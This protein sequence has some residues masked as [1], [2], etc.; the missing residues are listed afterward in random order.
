MKKH[1]LLS[2]LSLLSFS[3]MKAGNNPPLS[4]SGTYLVGNSQPVY[5]KLTHVAAALN[6]AA[7]TL[8]G[9]VIF[10][11]DSDYIG[12]TGETFPITF[13]QFKTSGGDWTV[14]IRPKAGVSKR[15]L[16]GAPSTGYPLIYV[17]GADRLV[18]DGRPGGTGNS[19]GWLV[20]NTAT[21]SAGPALY[22]YSDAQ[23]NTLTW[24]ELEGQ[25]ASAIVTL[26]DGETEGN[27]NN[28]I[29]YCD[30]SGRSDVQ[31]SPMAGILSQSGRGVFNSG[32]V[33]TRNRF[34]NICIAGERTAGINLGY[35]STAATITYNHFY[36]PTA[37]VSTKSFTSYNAIFTDEPAVAD[38]DISNNFIGG[39]AP[40]CGG[41][42]FSIIGTAS[43]TVLMRG[44]SLYCYNPTGMRNH[45]RN[46]TIRNIDLTSGLVSDGVPSFAAIQVV[47]PQAYITN[48]TIGSST[49]RDDIK[50]TLN[51]GRLLPQMIEFNSKFGGAITGNNIGGITIA[52]MMGLADEGLNCIYVTFTPSGPLTFDISNNT[53][54]SRTVSDNIRNLST[55]MQASFNGISAGIYSPAVVKCRNNTVD[56]VAWKLAGTDNIFIAGIKTLRSADVTTDSNHVSGISVTSLMSGSQARLDGITASGASVISNNTVTGLRLLNEAASNAS[57]V[58][59]IAL[60]GSAANTSQVYNNKIDDLAF[61][62]VS[63]SASLIGLDVDKAATVYNNLISLDNDEGTANCS[64]RGIRVNSATATIN[65]LHNSVYVGGNNGAASNAAISAPVSRAG[66]S[67]STTLYLR[68]NLLV[69]SRTGGNGSHYIYYNAATAPATNWPVTA[70]DYNVLVAVSNAR[71]GRWG[72]V[73]IDSAQWRDNRGDAH[74]SFY[75]VAQLAPSALFNDVSTGDLAIKEDAHQYVAGKGTS[76]T[77]VAMD[78]AGAIR[79]TTAPGAGAYESGPT[80]LPNT[81]PVITSHNGD[82]SVTLQVPENTTAVTTL[83]AADADEGTTLTYSLAGGEDAGKFVIGASTGELNFITA[84]DF[85]IPGDVNGDNVYVVTIQVSDGELTAS[86]RFKIRITNANDHAPVITSYNGDAAVTLRVPENTTA[87]IATVKAIDVDKNTTIIYSL[88]NEEDAVKFTVNSSTGELS[89]L[90][91]PDFEQ[92]ADGDHDNVY[93]IT[94]KASDGDSAATQRFKIKIQD[95]NDHAPVITSNDGRDTVM[96][97][98]AENM[99]AAIDTVNATDADAGS[100]IRYS[101]VNS[102]D[103]VVFSVDPVTGVLSFITPPDYEQPA[104]G[105]HDNVYIVIVQASDGDSTD[106]QHFEIKVTNNNDSPLIIT[107]TMQ[108]AE[109][110]QAVTTLGAADDDAGVTIS[111]ENE[112]DGSLFSIDPATGVLSF[113]TAPDFEIPGD[114]NGDNI[115]VVAIRMFDGTIATILQLNITITDADG[116][117]ARTTGRSTAEPEVQQ[118]VVLQLEAVPESSKGIKVY[119]N[120][121]AGKRFNLRMDSIATGRYTLELYTTAG[122]LVC[123]QQLNHTGKSALY[124]VQLPGSLARGMYVL[125]LTG[126]NTRHTEKLIIE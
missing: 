105:N 13:K 47:G 91:A 79:S 113:I 68:N 82:A 37:V 58:S 75:T 78:Y 109:N 45:I 35:G 104:D 88:V 119:P 30:I 10:E 92:P 62:G 64:V 44:I 7:N 26:G 73:D 63:V 99:A 77:G 23:D 93:V 6:N 95:V 14:T 87:V 107:S 54:G 84:P 27:N 38:M 25:S 111:I 100:T 29:S 12:T 83:T 32:N 40:E 46:N 28:T 124:P 114:G 33:I 69:N 76:G 97:Q 22:I 81:A 53:I 2:F 19:I 55:T 126:V 9:N 115:Y 61:A 34:Y 66:T 125:K 42:P 49:G 70:S 106:V 74:S 86:Q 50:I 39:S 20:R 43:N 85:E 1:L 11:L 36:Q 5:K 57:T 94:V 67:S 96:I 56:G 122:Q 116:S 4:L 80:V 24:L 101:I 121:V 51:G 18:L 3:D 15:T 72:T 117:S 71:I 89:F 110:T 120:P 59:G 123:K 103:G 65:V 112:G 108:L 41:A 60:T 102:G 21:T 98:V 31:G 48:N 16:A 17:Q 118:T 8:T 52:G 90:T